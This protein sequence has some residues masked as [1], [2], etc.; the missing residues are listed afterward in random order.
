[1]QSD[2]FL[3]SLSH[4]ISF[5]FPQLSCKIIAAIIKHPY[6]AVYFQSVSQLSILQVPCSVNEVLSC[7]TLT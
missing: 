6:N 2:K 1:M 4:S 5:V 7:P 3:N